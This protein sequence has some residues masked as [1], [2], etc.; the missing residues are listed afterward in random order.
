MPN[1]TV[2]LKELFSLKIFHD[3]L[4]TIFG[5]GVLKMFKTVKLV[6]CALLAMTGCNRTQ[7]EKEV[8]LIPRSIL[9][10]KPDKFAAF[11]NHLGNRIAY[12]ARNESEIELRV[13]DLDGNNLIKFPL[14]MAR[15]VRDFTWAYTGEH[16]LIPQDMN[17]DENNHVI[18][19]NIETGESKDLTPFPGTKSS[20]VK[21]SI[22]YPH[23]VIIASNKNDRKWFEA[24]RVNIITG[25]SSLV[26]KNNSYANFL[27]DSNFN[28][29]LVSKILPNGDHEIY[30]M[31]RRKPKFFKKIQFED[32]K[33]TFY[34]HFGE[35]CRTLYGLD[36][37]G[38][39][40][41]AL[42]E[43]DFT[44][45][46]SKTLF[47]NPK[48]DVSRFVCDPNTF[49]P[50]LAEVEVLKPESFVIDPVIQKDMEYLTE[51]A[52]GRTLRIVT[53]NRA[54]DVWLVRFSCPTIPGEY[55]IYR[56]D[57][58]NGNPL[59]LT[60]LFTERPSLQKYTLQE[61]DP[62]VIKSRDG[63]DLVCYLT[64]SVDFSTTV[65]RKL[66][67]Y[68]HGGPWAR[69]SWVFS[70]V[71]QLLA[72]RGYSILQVNYRGSTGF[73]KSFINAANGNL[74][75]IRND[76]LDCT[77]WAVANRITDQEHIAI[78]G[79]SFGGYS[80]LAGLTFSPEVFCCGVDVV[81]PSCWITLLESIPEYWIPYQNMWHRL[82]G[83][84][85][86]QEGRAL[87]NLESPIPLVKNIR[88]PLIIFHGKNDPR[89][90]E[91]EAYQIVEAMKNLKLP[92]VCVIYPDEG[93]G[94]L[95]EQNIKS[96]LALS[97]MFLSKYLGGQYEPIHPGE[98]EGS[99]HD[100]VA[101]NSI[102]RSLQSH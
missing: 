55:H 36:S 86:T 46:K 11:L 98:L 35:D 80:A 8:S 81:G 88:R 13:D 69:D 1:A 63:M 67:V 87:L 34:S 49:A 2:S 66:I 73:G 3:K 95:R 68:V 33:S 14:K 41:S 58:Q 64:K 61:T 32:T 21:R 29:R 97:E 9:L 20:V 48:A 99:S 43:Y 4:T 22:K 62:V 40:K 79:A 77:N 84:H 71:N 57:V 31:N 53:R 39:D 75:K 102:I 24:Y 28:L 50:Q 74:A 94:F 89:V 83:D 101:G 37:V 26:F 12:L 91:R 100:I 65:H 15:D 59:S 76:I 30:L 5:K 90:K 7:Q 42:V 72:N 6:C 16:I 60:L 70:S 45:G 10:A 47:E 96:Y 78:M 18:C 38:R 93:H 52:N 19:L 82:I 54:D 25:K 92:V 85:R 51:Q 56:R 44:T 17:G 27:F 23:E